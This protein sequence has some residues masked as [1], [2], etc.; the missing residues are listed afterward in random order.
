MIIYIYYFLRNVGISTVI[1]L[2]NNF[3]RVLFLLFLLILLK[4][5]FKVFF[6]LLQ[7]KDTYKYRW[8]NNN[9]KTKYF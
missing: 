1:A 3:K 5:I 8:L 7:Q 4:S 9:I 6:T 2:L